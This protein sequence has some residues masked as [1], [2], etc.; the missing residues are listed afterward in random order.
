M[1]F[2]SSS[3][4]F[5]SIAGVQDDSFSVVLGIWDDEM[6]IC[7]AGGGRV[8]FH[9]ARL[10]SMENHD[11]TVIE[12]DPK[13]AEQVDFALDVRVVA[14]NAS[15]ILLL[16]EAGVTEADVFVATTWT[17]EVN[18]IAAAT[19]SLGTKQTLRGWTGPCT[20]SPTFCM[21]RCWGSTTF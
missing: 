21:R 11:V 6:N 5:D 3:W 10:L 18:L 2:S 13:R 17:D 1:N 16:K 7:I 12:L 4:L 14:G 8:G 15:S 19:K 9:V 20:S